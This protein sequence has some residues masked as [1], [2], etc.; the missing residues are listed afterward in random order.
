MT[1]DSNDSGI[2]VTLCSSFLG[3]YTHAGF[4]A[5][6]QAE[7]L[8]PK[9]LAGASSGGMVAGLTAAGISPQDQLEFYCSK[10]FRYSFLEPKHMICI[11]FLRLLG[12]PTTGLST[13]QRTVGLLREILGNRRIEDCP[14][15]KL[16]LAVTNLTLGR[17]E[18]RQVGPLAETIMASCAYPT[19]IQQ[20]QLGDELF[21]DGGI[22][23]DGPFGQWLGQGQV[24][25]I[26]LHSVGMPS[27]RLVAGRIGIRGGL[28][29]CLDAIGAELFRLR[30]ELAKLN[31]Q[32]VHRWNTP[33]KRPLLF[34]SEA[35]GRANYAVGEAMGREAARTLKPLKSLS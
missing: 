31:H 15:A 29:R 7:G 24:T 4:L 32:T 1:A 35:T 17:S 25:T 23:N 33:T 6:L 28:H 3:F 2:G 26:L 10:A 13:G 21:W 34:I 11:P 5:G 12:R 14:Q 30:N 18:I 19:M 8:T 20:Q 22:A 16:A 9:H 27:H